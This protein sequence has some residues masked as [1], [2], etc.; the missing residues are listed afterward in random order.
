MCGL[1]YVRSCW[2]ECAGN[3]RSYVHHHVLA[4][5]SFLASS[6]VGSS[7]FASMFLV[8]HDYVDFL[9]ILVI[10]AYFLAM[11]KK[12]H[13]YPKLYLLFVVLAVSMTIAS[14]V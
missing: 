2:Q 7:H 11:I 13:N 8:Q 1:M 12:D 10:P 9:R 3:E 5:L 14:N 6:R 4:L